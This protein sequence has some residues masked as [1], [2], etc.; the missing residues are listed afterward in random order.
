MPLFLG[1]RRSYRS[2]GPT[3]RDYYNHGN[4]LYF[5]KRFSD[6]IVN[7]N[8]VIQ[9]SP[10]EVM[11]Y[12]N[13]GK[14]YLKL[15]Q[16]NNAVLDFLKA[17]RLQP[18]LDCAYRNLQK[19]DPKTIL[20]VIKAQDQKQEIVLLKQCLNPS[21]MV[22]KL[23]IENT[24]SASCSTAITLVEEIQ[25]TLQG[26]EELQKQQEELQ[27]QQIEEARLARLERSGASGTSASASRSQNEGDSF[28]GNSIRV[29]SELF[30]REA[31]AAQQPASVLSRDERDQIDEAKKRMK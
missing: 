24:Q 8:T 19:F 10:G 25:Q 13:R 28:W 31:S 15:G 2:A 9:L 18:N 29:L 4:H 16:Q 26:L 7:Y 17:L 14:S 3:V 20:D 23:F 6:A 11:A 30:S 12:N 1:S 27:K 5:M 22:S 21:G